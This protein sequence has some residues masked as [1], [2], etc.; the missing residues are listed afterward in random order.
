MTKLEP[1]DAII[2]NKLQPGKQ[3][4][5]SSVTTS[6]YRTKSEE[7][8]EMKKV[9]VVEEES[10]KCSKPSSTTS[11]SS[12]TSLEQSKPLSTTSSEWSSSQP[13]FDYKNLLVNYLPPSMDST[14][15]RS[16]FAPYGTIVSSKVVVNHKSGLSKGYGFVEFESAKDGIKA[17]KALDR[18]EIR[19]KTLKVSFSRQMRGKKANH[20][21]NLYL[22][23]LDPRMETDDLQRYFKICG[24]VVQCTVL[25]NAAGVSKQIGFVRYNDAESA[26]RAIDMFD[27]QQLEGT[28]RRIKIRIA[29]TPRASQNCDAFHSSSSMSSPKSQLCM[30]SSSSACYVSGFRSSLPEK[31]LRKVFEP[32]G[33]RKV[34]NIRIIRRQRSPFA[35][36]NFFNKEDAADAAYECN[37][38]KLGNRVL[39]VRLQT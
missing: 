36:I 8:V 22:S 9:D 32:V 34:K 29:G 28:D 16:L 19:Q 1:D 18:H 4:K 35:F 6:V 10:S 14:H 27:G 12:K 5:G 21:T 31:V 23:N 15:L 3:E 20:K 11:S 25:K 13:I 37:N 7:R 2:V 38:I 26:R 30:N 33:G 24:Y 17:Q 39:T